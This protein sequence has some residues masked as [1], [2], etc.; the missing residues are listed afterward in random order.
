MNTDPNQSDSKEDLRWQPIVTKYAK[1][2]L[3]RSL[4]QVANTLIPYF[5]CGA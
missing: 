1:P 5:A 4:W 3:A 2:D